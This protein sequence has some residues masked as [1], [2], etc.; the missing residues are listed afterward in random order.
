M[1][2]RWESENSSLL[3]KLRGKE[4][5]YEEMIRLLKERH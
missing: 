3:G 5:D 4:S 1:K 2:R